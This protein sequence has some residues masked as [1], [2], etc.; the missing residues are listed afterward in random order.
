MSSVAA[1]PTGAKSAPAHH[2]FLY[3]LAAVA[4][5]AGPLLTQPFV[6]RTLGEE[7]WGR[8]AFS[9]SLVS[10]GLIV[11]LVGLPL[12]IT[13]VHFDTDS[14]SL[15][16]RSLAA[17]GMLQSTAIALVSAALL[18][19][20][21]AANGTLED[22]LSFV[23]ALLVVGLHGCTQMCLAVL[24][25]EHRAPV[26]VV[27]TVTAQTLGHLAGLVMV[28]T[29]AA[30][31]TVYMVSFGVVVA[32]AAAIGVV[33]VR[34]RGPFKFPGVVGMSLRMSLPILPHSVAL[35]LM[36]QGESFLVTSF[37]GPSLYGYYG[38]M[39]PLALGPL[40]VIMAL[41]NVWETTIL[42]HK[43]HDPDGAVR[44]IQVE[45][46]AVGVAL[47]L[48]ASAAAV[49]AGHILFEDPTSEQLQLARLLPFMAAGY[50]VF[51]ISTTQ[52][53][54]IG[55]TR[56][57]AIVTP[58]VAALDFV[59]S[60]GPALQGNLF[61]VGLAKVVSFAALGLAHLAISRKYD[62]ALVNVRA[63][64]LCLL[65]SALSVGLML[66]L[67]TDYVLGLVTTAVAVVLLAGSAGVVWRRIRKTQAQAAA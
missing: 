59:L 53:V 39:L 49:F 17:F 19:A 7:E 47:T 38:A 31:A 29:F 36:L 48:A 11:I 18:A 61:L 32:V 64:A 12:I 2:R 8:V 21:M 42:A 30:T 35:V 9:N 55:K 28:L 40:A 14:G 50:V 51:L 65:L 6:Q 63:M 62:P 16:S 24:R 57:M 52:M 44:R 15:K 34:P 46:A 26:F 23:V 25:A 1:P 54:A 4:Q 45:A 33:A 56:L 58:A 41:S 3:L 37:H 67:P 27:I 66:L 10:V 60:I 43:G 20:V 13:R 22:D 5:G